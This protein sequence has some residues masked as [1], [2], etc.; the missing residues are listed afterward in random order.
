MANEQKEIL[1]AV[2]AARQIGVRLGY[3]YTLVREGLLRAERVDGKWR[4][5]RSAIEAF[6][7]RRGIK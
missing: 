6:R 7:K 4:V 3:F 2:E 1:N 5:E